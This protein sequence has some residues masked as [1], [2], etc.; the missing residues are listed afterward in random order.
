V[1]KIACKPISTMSGVSSVLKTER[2][3]ICVANVCDQSARKYKENFSAE[4]E[5]QGSLYPV[6]RSGNN[7]VSSQ[8]RIAVC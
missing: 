7:T 1:I 8:V 3:N 2:D 5:N 6:L 4:T